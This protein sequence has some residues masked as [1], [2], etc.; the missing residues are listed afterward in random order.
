MNNGRR[1][2]YICYFGVSEPLVQ[3]QVIPYLRELVKGGHEV[4][5]LT[6]EPGEVDEAAVSDRLA[7]DG[8]GWHWLRYHK[9]PSVPATMF[10]IANGVR[11]V[12]K[13][14][15][16][17]RFEILHSRSHV[18]MVMAVLGRKLSRLGP[19]LLFDIRGFFPEEYTDAGIWPEG[20]WLYRSVKRVERWLMREADGFVVLTNR[21]RDILANQIGDRPAEVIPCCVD[22]SRFAT[23]GEESRAEIRQ[24]LGIGDRYVAAYVGAFGGWYLT[25]ETADFLGTLKR[26]RPN[27]FALIL[28]QSRPEAIEPLLKA[29]GYGEGDYFISKVPADKI[30]EYLSAAD[31]AVSFIKPC[32]SKLASSPTKNAEYLACGLPIVVNDGVGDTTE[33]TQADRTGVVIS[34]F[35]T[36]AYTEALKEVEE[37]A[38]DGSLPDRSR[39]SARTRFDLESVGGRKY[40]RIYL[41]LLE[42]TDA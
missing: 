15:R 17:E 27:S 3:T 22:L 6:F 20:G 26:L 30:P 10:D 37:L 39:S 41:R 42:K 2:L 34:E 19:K 16:R 40:L 7:A 38:A 18:P 36:A 28:T 35:S 1:S 33:F 25:E 23:A 24:Q 29:R 31:I 5:L 32:F 14:V 8:I 4:S 11:F 21:S 12:A 9:R 13:L